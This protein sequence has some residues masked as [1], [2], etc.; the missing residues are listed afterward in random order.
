[1]PAAA[2]NQLIEAMAEVLHLT[3][4]QDTARP[5]HLPVG[6]LTFGVATS[7]GPTPCAWPCFLLHFKPPRRGF[8]HSEDLPDKTILCQGDGVIKGDVVVGRR[9]CHVFE[10]FGWSGKHKRTFCSIWLCQT[11]TRMGHLIVASEKF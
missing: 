11:Q 4:A 10:T 3:G 1:M 2:S 9:Q 8:L 7:S 6:P 5:H